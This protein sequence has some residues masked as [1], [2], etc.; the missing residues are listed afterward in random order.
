MVHAI[1]VPGSLLCR[2]CLIS[3]HEPGLVFPACYGQLALPEV[4]FDADLIEELVDLPM[5]KARSVSRLQNF[6]RTRG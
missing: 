2:R 1:E 5:V 6:E 3:P 4:I